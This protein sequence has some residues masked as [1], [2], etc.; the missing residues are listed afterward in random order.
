MYAAAAAGRVQNTLFQLLSVIPAGYNAV[1][2]AAKDD[3][4]IEAALNAKFALCWALLNA[5]TKDGF[6]RVVYTAGRLLR[7]LLCIMKVPALERFVPAAPAKVAAL[8]MA[9][10]EVCDP[11]T[12]Q[13]WLDA[14]P[15]P[16]LDVDPSAELAAG[17]APQALHE[18]P[19]M[20]RQVHMLGALA[21]VAAE[22]R[23]DGPAGH[24]AAA[25]LQAWQWAARLLW[26]KSYG[27]SVYCT[28]F[29]LTACNRRL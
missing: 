26:A 14:A 3:P 9:V 25:A 8:L 18:N 20:R 24:T 27:A 15:F 13:R 23:P 7:E 22:Q 21:V 5:R 4:F 1:A 12:L 29:P 19:L 16:C 2:F 6:G 28:E 17:V 11:D 10:A